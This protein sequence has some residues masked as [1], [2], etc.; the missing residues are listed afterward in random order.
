VALKTNDIRSAAGLMALQSISGI[1]PKKALRLALFAE[2]PSPALGKHPSSW[3][4]LLTAAER[5][6][7]ASE[8]HGVRAI[9]IFEPDYPDRLR[10]IPDPPPVLFIQGSVGS[11]QAER[12]VAIVGT[13]EPTEFGCSA[14]EEIVAAL[15]KQK[16]VVVSGLAKGIDS[17]AHGA[18]LKH[19]TPTAAVMAGGLDRIYPKQNEELARAIVDQAGALLSEQRW[20]KSPS[21]AAFVQRNRI[22]SGLSAALLVIQTGITG[23]TMHTVRHAATQGRPIFCALPHSRHERNAGLWALLE[24]PA[25]RLYETLP[26]WKDAAALCSKL[27]TEPLAKPITK[28]NLGDFLEALDQIIDSDPQQNPEDRWWPQPLNSTSEPGEM[29]APDDEHAPLLGFASR[30]HAA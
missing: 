1:G 6:I 24:T 11:L 26:A 13:R 27:G 28:K 22:Q 9:S 18:A 2:D 19:H 21:R 17:F 10:A 30:T 29:V 3:A 12:V 15:A 5:E 4:K 7:A 23:G 16:W 25:N 14:T 8:E 20:G